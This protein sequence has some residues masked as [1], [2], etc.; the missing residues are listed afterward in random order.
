VTVTTADCRF[1]VGDRYYLLG[2]RILC[3]ADYEAHLRQFGDQLQLCNGH[4]PSA[5]MAIQLPPLD[6]ETMMSMSDA[7]SWYQPSP[8]LVPGRRFHPSTES[9][10][11]FDDRSSGYGSPSPPCV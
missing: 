11:F 3:E 2:A 8:Q 9:H 6:N 4:L 7:S 10:K 5:S 1:C